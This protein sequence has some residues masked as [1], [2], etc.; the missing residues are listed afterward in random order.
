MILFLDFDCVLH[1]CFPLPDLLDAE[2]AYFSSWPR[3][4]AVLEEFPH[5]A[6][7]VSSSWRSIT[8][9]RWA[10]EVP[11][12]LKARITGRT[13]EIKRPVRRQYPADYQPEPMRFLEI[14]QH[15]KSTRQLDR[16][17]VALDDDPRLFPADCQNLILCREGFG[18]DE[19]AALRARFSAPR[20]PVGQ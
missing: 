9:E 5:V 15:L 7:V 1:P 12:S 20:V 14:Q 16:P 17:W 6:V 11:E 19:A 8:P 2:N 3:L 13:P 4:L 10:A 18:E